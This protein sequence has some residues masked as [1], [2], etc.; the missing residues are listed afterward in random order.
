MVTELMIT[1]SQPILLVAVTTLLVLLMGKHITV[2]GGVAH[3][4]V[5]QVLISDSCTTNTLT[6]T[7]L[8]LTNQ[9]DLM[10]VV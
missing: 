8:V 9:T 3:K 7:D 1:I 6:Y 2:T 5:V 4:A 10:C